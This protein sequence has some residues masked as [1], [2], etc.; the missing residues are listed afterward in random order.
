ML[1][2]V[3]ENGNGQVEI[4]VRA[5]NGGYRYMSIRMRITRNDAG[6]PLYRYGNIRDTTE[7][8]LAE[9][10]HAKLIQTIEQVTESIII[11]DLDGAI[12]YVN[13]AFGRINGYTRDEVMGSNPRILKSGN[14]PDSLYKEMWATLLRGET[15]SGDLINKRKD[16]TKYNKTTTISPIKDP[17]GR[18]I[19]YVAVS[20]D[21]THELSL[22]DQLNR[23][24]KMESMGRLAGGVAHDFNNLLMVI[25]SF[26]EL[27][28]A[29][30]PVEDRLRR[31][32]GQVLAA[33]KRGSS[34][35]GQML[36]FSR[37]Q[38]VS[39]VALDLNALVDES[40]RMLKR[41]IGED[42]DFRIVPGE[43][44]WTIRAD[45]DH[46][47]QILMNLSVN[48]RDAMPQGGT[49]TIATENVV[50][51]QGGIGGHPLVPPGNYVKISVTD[52]GLGIGAENREKIFEPFFTTKEVGKGTGLGL[53]TVYGI[54]EQ[55]GGR[56]LV[57]SEL[58]HGACFTIYWPASTQPLNTHGSSKADAMQNGSETVLVVEDENYLRDGI[59]EFLR[60]LGYKVFSASS[61]PIALTIALDN[62]QIDLLLTDIVMPK[63]SGTELSH[64]LKGMLP[65]MKVIFMSGYTGEE[66]LRT[67]NQGSHTPLLQKPFGL[68]TL[69][70]RVRDAFD[71]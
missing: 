56:V 22:R 33:V 37:K 11:T 14:H 24:Q 36:A 60:S 32:T 43:L 25:Q 2:S 15:W 13:P 34:L 69:A 21:V 44:L 4:R 27:L 55:S 9:V 57:D 63:M 8:K 12:V 65:D 28:Q 59:C 7:R 45:P 67:Y 3:E 54:V 18:V 38:V 39:P 31:Y 62:P 71:K 5:K 70:Q 35:T 50:V 20:R 42:I 68:G 41:L 30:F 58:G 61:G 19:N 53:A 40:A 48:S 16:G 6:V 29:Q 26:T 1:A 49:L 51:G 52:T 66:F 46:L 47:F 17:N 64:K 23:S 10:E